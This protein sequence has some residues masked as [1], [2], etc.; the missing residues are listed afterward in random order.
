MSHLS[1][2][3]HP[4]LNP[5]PYAAGTMSHGGGAMEAGIGM[6]KE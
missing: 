5:K 1:L 6:G 3:Q 2:K 4:K